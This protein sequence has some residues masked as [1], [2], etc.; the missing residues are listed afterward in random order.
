MPPINSPTSMN[1]P[2]SETNLSKVLVI[3]KNDLDRI[4]GHLNKK[5]KEE[6]SANEEL[7]RRKELHEKSLALTRNWNNTIQVRTI[8]A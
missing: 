2:T 1:V 5:Q 6:E 7:L 3:T 4:T 8:E